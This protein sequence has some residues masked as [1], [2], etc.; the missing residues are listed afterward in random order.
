MYRCRNW[1]NGDIQGVPS[2]STH[3]QFQFLTLLMVLSKKSNLQFEPKWF[4][5]N[6]TSLTFTKFQKLNNFFTSEK[7]G[8][9][10]ESEY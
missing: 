1:T 3:F 7:S 6:F 5:L 10:I 4:N 9:V 2:I 8:I